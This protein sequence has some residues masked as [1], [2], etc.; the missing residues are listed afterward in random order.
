[1]YGPSYHD[2]AARRQAIEAWFKTEGL[3]LSRG[4]ITDVADHIDHIVKVAGIDHV[5]IGSDF[6]GITAGPRDSTM[7]PHTHGSP[8][9]CCAGILRGRHAQDPG[10]QRAAGLPPG[11]SRRPAAPG[12]HAAG[13][14]R[15]QGG[16]PHNSCIGCHQQGASAM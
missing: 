13:S 6:D 15:D 7:S 10:R 16:K 4:T 12:K 11:G 8:R 3:K 1:M 14:G 5:G 2:P 9:N